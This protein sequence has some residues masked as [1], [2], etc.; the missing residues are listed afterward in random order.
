MRATAA[1]VF[2]FV[3]NLV[4]QVLGPLVVGFLN[5]ALHAAYGDFAIRYSLIVGAICAAVAGAAL[6]GASRTLADD[7]QR[8]GS[9]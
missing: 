7:S 5:D 9:T 8:A 1:A 2:L 3:A 4:G 6:I